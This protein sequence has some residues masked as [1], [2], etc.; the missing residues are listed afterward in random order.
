MVTKYN[1]YDTRKTAKIFVRAV[2]EHICI[3]MMFNETLF[4]SGLT[5][6]WLNWFKVPIYTAAFE[7][8]SAHFD[9]K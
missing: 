4:S 2:L 6:E 9:F 1:E 5:C 8:Y 3:V 7:L